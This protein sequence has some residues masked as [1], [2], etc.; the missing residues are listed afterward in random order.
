[1]NDCPRQNPAYGRLFLS[2]YKSISYNNTGDVGFAGLASFALMLR[3]SRKTS[4]VAVWRPEIDVL[5][6]KHS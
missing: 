5:S 4:T 1:M 2:L 3:E 6:R